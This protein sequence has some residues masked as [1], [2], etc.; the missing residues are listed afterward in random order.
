MSRNE[1]GDGPHL[2]S[3]D[4]EFHVRWNLSE[5]FALFSVGQ[6]HPKRPTIKAFRLILHGLGSRTLN[7]LDFYRHV[8][9]TFPAI[10]LRASLF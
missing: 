7:Q 3:Q 2:F 1:V 8:S 10:C 5:H 9:A 4:G 6:M